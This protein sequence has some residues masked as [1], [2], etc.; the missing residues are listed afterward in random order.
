MEP[1]DN[2]HLQI[3]ND[4]IEGEEEEDD[5]DEAELEEESRAFKCKSCNKFYKSRSSLSRHQKHECQKEPTYACL[6]TN[7]SYKGKYAV[8]VKRHMARVHPEFDV[9]EVKKNFFC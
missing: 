7:C 5:D 6:D 8:S 9:G 4:T 3:Y 2:D 1:Y